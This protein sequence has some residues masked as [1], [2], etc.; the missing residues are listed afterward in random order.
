MTFWARRAFPPNSNK[1]MVPVDDATTIATC[2]PK[3]NEVTF[4]LAIYVCARRESG[5]YVQGLSD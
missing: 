4:L 2:R 5:P 3:N 1:I